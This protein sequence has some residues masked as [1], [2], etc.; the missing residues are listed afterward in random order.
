M[1]S[2][3]EDSVERCSRGCRKSKQWLNHTSCILLCTV[4]VGNFKSHLSWLSRHY[5]PARLRNSAQMA[6]WKTKGSERCR[7]FVFSFQRT[8]A[9]RILSMSR[10]LVTDTITYLLL[11]ASKGRGW[12]REE[13]E[14]SRNFWM[15]ED[16]M[17]ILELFLLIKTVSWTG[18]CLLTSCGACWC[19]SD[20]SWKKLAIELQF[21]AVTHVLDRFLLPARKL[22]ETVIGWSW[23]PETAPYTIPTFAINIFFCEKSILTRYTLSWSMSYL[24]STPAKWIK[25]DQTLGMI[26]NHAC[27]SGLDPATWKIRMSGAA[28][29]TFITQEL[30]LNH[31]SDVFFMSVFGGVPWKWMV[32]VQCTPKSC[33]KFVFLDDWWDT[34]TWCNNM[35]VYSVPMCIQSIF[36]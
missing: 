4:V 27:L 21:A 8:E 24:W 7:V 15:L 36:S 31:N 18:L 33:K 32:L 9:Q 34:D 1:L 11:G 22:P 28:A 25:M 29:V 13:S 6:I 26:G 30:N 23:M 17:E 16:G 19:W 20:R 3:S 10:N 5:Y 14:T 2:W 35:H 12:T